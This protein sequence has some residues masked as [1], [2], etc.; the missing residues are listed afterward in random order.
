[1][2]QATVK[3]MATTWWEICAITAL[4]LQPNSKQPALLPILTKSGLNGAIKG[5]ALN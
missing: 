2:S 4:A 5:L 1:M 3:H